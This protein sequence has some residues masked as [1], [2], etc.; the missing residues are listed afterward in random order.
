M[1]NFFYLY[2]G[3][4]YAGRKASDHPSVMPAVSRVPTND[5][6]LAEARVQSF[7]LSIDY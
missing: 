2:S 1:S 7:G 5:I 4:K 3:I 6:L